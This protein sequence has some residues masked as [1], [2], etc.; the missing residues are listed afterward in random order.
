VGFKVD[1]ILLD[2]NDDNV[3]VNHQLGVEFLMLVGLGRKY[4][5]VACFVPFVPVAFYFVEVFGFGYDVSCYD[6][7][8]CCFVVDGCAS[9]E[10]GIFNGGS[11]DGRNEG[12]KSCC[13]S[14]E[15]HRCEMGCD[16]VHIPFYL[17]ILATSSCP[18]GVVL[19]SIT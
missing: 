7:G 6:D 13:E 16:S 15:L 5:V 1:H 2:L 19:W 8:F 11:I 4:F 12:E 10:E 18:R 9:G 3:D 14:R 17:E